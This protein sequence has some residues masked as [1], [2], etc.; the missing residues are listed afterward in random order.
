MGRSIGEIALDLTI[1]PGRLMKQVN[2]E[3]NNA[4][5]VIEGNFNRSFKK[6]GAMAAAAL[7][8]R[9]IGNFV[10]DCL[11]LGSD[12]AEVQ[13]VVD[14]AFPHMTKRV[15][16]FAKNSMEQFG[17]SETVA[18]NYMG[19]FGAMSKAFGYN[20]QAAESMSET[21]TGLA[22]DVASF[23]NMST[24]EAFTKLKSVFTGETESLK[25]LGV[26][27]TETALNAFAMAN[28]FGKTVNKMTE[29]EKVALRLA[30]V[31]DKLSMAS[32]DF[33]KT[34]D[35]WANQ[36]R[37]LTL[38]FD[39]L[40]ASLGKGFIALFTPIVKGINWVLAAL[41][42]LADS[43][44][45]MME[46]LTGKKTETSGGGIADNFDSTA[47]AANNASNAVQN[48]GDSV[49][50]ASDKAGKASDNAAKKAKKNA[51]AIQKAFAKIDTINKLT[52]G[53]NSD[54]SSDPSSGGKPGGGKGSGG[55][56]A[57]S[58]NMPI[59]KAVDFGK[60]TQ[61][62]NIFSNIMKD[63][64][65]EIT[66]LKDLFKSGFNLG[67]GNSL[68][69]IDSI[70]S[71]LESIDTSLKDIFTDSNVV[72][73][74]KRMADNI[75]FNLG[76]VTGSATRI[77]LTFI[78]LFTGSI[79]K[80]LDSNKEF[81]K[82]K[83]IEIFDITSKRSVIIG[84]FSLVV[85]DIAEVFR[86]ST[87][88]NIGSNLIGIIANGAISSMTLIY[89]LG[90]D[91]LN[92]ITQP[93]I[94]NK[95][96]I[97]EAIQSTLKPIDSVIE[98]IKTTLDGLWMKVDDVYNN[99][100]KPAIDAVSGAWSA[101][102]KGFLN[103]YNTFVVPVLNWFANGFKHTMEGPVGNAINSVKDAFSTLWDA[104]RDFYTSI[105]P[106]ANFLGG[107]FAGVLGLVGGILGGAFLIALNV[108]SVAVK[109][110]A[111]TIKAIIDVFRAF[112]SVVSS[113][114]SGSKNAIVAFKE[115]AVNAF[116]GAKSIMSS[117][118]SW[119]KS[120][121]GPVFGS[122]FSAAKTAVN[123]FKNYLSPIFNSIKGV[124]NGIT[125][126]LSGVFTNNWRR[127]WNGV[128]SIFSN[129]VGGFANIFKAPLNAM[130]GGVNAMI[131]GLNKVKIPD[132]V[133]VVGGKG[134]NI[135]KI[136]KL[137]QGGYVGPNQ[138][139][140]AMI[141]DN[142]HYGEIVAPENKLEDMVDNALKRQKESGNLQGLDILISL[143]REL[144]ELVKTLK[145]KV[146]LDMKRLSISLENA[147]RERKMIGG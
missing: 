65:A 122:V 52:F 104:V 86:S 111:D 71:N 107:A 125:S 120:T 48:A 110:L 85:A 56:G 140:L 98:I 92:A 130:I 88:K 61:G 106:V 37:V 113:I 117:L 42:P 123:G 84:T 70:K 9:A 63:I 72:S 53:N 18:K 10:S 90:T 136:P 146:D 19:T 114:A 24:D 6:I 99:H 64:I 34:S 36:T 124:F 57:G 78:D 3:S 112:G 79:S 97:I 89:K 16:E 59:G 51:K 27:M 135:P 91:I 129:I 58:G 15:N 67:F 82:R 2:N 133:P 49:S 105:Q 25:S 68:E 43:F 119:L 35:S 12:L 22:G 103:G 73:A 8:V 11:K 77:G 131:G 116:N 50:G 96:A 46:F 30:F 134:I 32:G 128:K 39:A 80:Y 126:F 108:V 47:S 141:G 138:P 139:R 5:K 100:I 137:A 74:A 21:L 1:N 7:S 132:W 33:A 83:L 121:F 31:T 94:T 62:A 101:L 29:Q 54:S 118:I 20:E 4:A 76:L 102:L 17:L 55:S 81:L 13:N 127:A 28:G 23:Y 144:I 45:S 38:R 14:T 26:V 44:A 115:G 93:I 109:F 40:K 143:I 147:Q 87:A 142:R 69:I 66:R 41:K 145:I 60:P 95:N 75:I